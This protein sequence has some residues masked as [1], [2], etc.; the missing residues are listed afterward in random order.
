MRTF[1]PRNPEVVRQDNIAFLKTEWNLKVPKDASTEQIITA[2]VLLSAGWDY[3]LLQDPI[4]TAR[5]L[6]WK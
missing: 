4:A 2:I 5:F 3:D 1:G 6:G